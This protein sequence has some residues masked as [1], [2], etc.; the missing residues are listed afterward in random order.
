MRVMAKD[1]AGV[2][3]TWRVGRRRL[4]WRPDYE[5]WAINSVDTTGIVL[6]LNV[7]PLALY[8][9]TWIAALVA[10]TITW[11]LRAITGRW[12]VVAY[13]ITTGD[14]IYRIDVQGR[15]AADA[16]AQRWALE[17]KQHGQPQATAAGA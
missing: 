6:V 17:I 13:S 14:T 1:E 9:V 4:A 11:P 7:I 15:G 12:P 16:L 10:T 2:W 8:L 3:A 5:G